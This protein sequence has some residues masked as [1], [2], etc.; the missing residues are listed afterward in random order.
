M[1]QMGLT[2]AKPYRR[3]ATS[4]K[5]QLSDTGS[6][7]GT[8]RRAVGMK[9]RERGSDHYLDGKRMA[10]HAIYISGVLQCPF[11]FLRR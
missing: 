1:V 2:F 8:W 9:K 10:L 5:S 3:H 6:D 11:T 7:A 4:G